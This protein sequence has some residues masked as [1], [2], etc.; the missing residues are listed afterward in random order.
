MLLADK[1]VEGPRPHPGRQRRAA[2]DGVGRI[3]HVREELTGHSPK[4]DGSGRPPD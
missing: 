2:I 1:L 4:S 3:F